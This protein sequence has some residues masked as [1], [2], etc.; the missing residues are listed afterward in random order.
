MHATHR[1]KP[2]LVGE[3]SE[4]HITLMD[5]QLAATLAAIKTKLDTLTQTM[6]PSN[7]KQKIGA[8]VTIPTTRE[9]IKSDSTIP[10]EITHVIKEF[11]DVFQEIS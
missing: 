2:H 6:E 3:S 8:P 11:S 7:Q 1:G 4:S 9:V 5:F 10:L